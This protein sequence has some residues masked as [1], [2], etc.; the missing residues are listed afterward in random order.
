MPEDLQNDP[1]KIAHA[2][3]AL[4]YL[5]E[6]ESHFDKISDGLAHFQR[7]ATLGTLSSMVAHEYN[8][9]LTPAIGYLQMALANPDDRQLTQK[10]MQNALGNI[11]KASQICSSLLDYAQDH[12]TESR[13]DLREC[14]QSALTCMAR[15][16]E[17]DGLE[18]TLDIQDAK[19][20]MLPVN[21]Q[22]VL[23]NLILNAQKAVG[24]SGGTLKI[25]NRIDGELARI[26]VA[27]DGPGIPAEIQGQVFKPFAT[28]K[29]PNQADSNKGSGLGLYICKNLVERVGGEIRFESDP[30][31]G[32]T[33][34][35]N[36]PIAKP[37]RKTA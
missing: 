2:Q 1:L 33:F 26:T 35:L 7:L 30:T 34:Y 9:I 19:L 21:L 20:A 11:E 31:S 4:D 32:T 12:T 14:I 36:I 8:N 6:V 15:S 10:A 37:L 23:V 22:Q 28:H 17:K 25:G 3:E 27:D 18:V 29:Q 13:A 5:Q 16:P 24:R